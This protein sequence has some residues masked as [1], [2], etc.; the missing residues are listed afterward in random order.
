MHPSGRRTTAFAP[1]IAAVCIVLLAP[2][3]LALPASAAAP[4][5]RYAVTDL[6]T[7][8][9]G[10]TSV[11]DAVNNAG[12]VVGYSDVTPNG[13]QHA[14]KWS[15]GAMVDLGTEAGGG[16]SRA[17]AVNDAGQVAGTADRQ[18]GGYGYP[19]RWSAAGV[20]QD[21][22]GP[23]TNRLG[24]GN[25]IDPAGRVA[26]G[27]RPADSEGGPLAIF[28]DQAG[29]PT[30]LGS[31]PDSLNAATGVN[32]QDEVVGS[33]A[34]TWHA[35]TL[36][37]LPYLPG[38]GGAGANAVNVSGTVVG[39]VALPGPAGGQ[40][41]ALWQNGVLTDLGTVDAIPYNQATAIN[42]AGQIV[43]TAD[44]LCQPCVAPL[45]WLRQPGG[46]L[47]T[48][49]SLLP[50]G[51]GWNLQRANGINDRGQI[52]GAGLH[53]GSL[54]AFLLSPVFSATVNFEPAGAPVPTGYTADTG[55]VYGPRSGGLSYGWNLAN[56]ANTRTRTSA[57]APDP[58]Y[59][60]L[61]HLQ[62]PGSATVWELAVPNG[63][64]TVHVVSGDPDFTD[65]TYRLTAEGA[66][67]LSG[68]PTAAAHW[69]EGTAQVTV[70]D[71]RLTL[72][73][74]SGSSNDK[75]DY[76]DVIAS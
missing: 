73:N 41:A 8:G 10:S 39:T 15:G 21:L 44:P 28:Y 63:R 12:V 69:V 72:A 58:R 17:N 60:T 23:I 71:G 33:P 1:R 36:T 67:V 46:A 11:A 74:A 43:G 16:N 57:S 4:A 31:P 24:V 55:A 45:A 18:P 13:T 25:A 19:V 30:E 34:F 48:L 68:T 20:I 2:L 47:T 22:G 76:I 70:S 6:G 37:M 14:F 49:N 59:N 52:V 66:V 64:Y 53:N 50:A 42:A 27:Q 5:A 29:N 7:L 62:R 3:P 9:T 32:A 40:D 35:G 75:I 51:S 54:H 26:G 65:S 56:S 38:G 61:I